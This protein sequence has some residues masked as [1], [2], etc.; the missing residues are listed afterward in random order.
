MKTAILLTGRPGCGKTTLIRKIV[1]SLDRPAGGFYTREMRQGG[2]RVGFEMVTLDGRS[3]VLAHVEFNSLQRVGNYG[4]DLSAL[5]GLGVGA[6]R[7]ALQAGE[8]VVVDEIGPMELRSA[9]FRQAVLEI[10]GSD[11]SM[12]GSIAS[13]ETPFTDQV[14]RHPSVK[15]IEVTPANRE[16]LV[17]R[18]LEML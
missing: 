9:R 17:A 7:A 14:K 5:D 2:R 12:L 1:A 8:L 15:L 11:K 10:L 13:K 3:A 18:I 6:L 16:A 4:L